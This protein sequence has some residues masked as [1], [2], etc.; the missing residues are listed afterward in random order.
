MA[1]HTRQEGIIG[2]FA[3]NPVAANLLML[4]IIV[5]GLASYFGI[6]KRTFPEFE[7]NMVQITVPYLGAAPA[8]VEEGVLIKIEEAVADV[9]GVK[10]IRSTANEGSGVVTVEILTGYDPAKALDDIKLRVDAIPNFPAETEKPVIAEVLFEQQVIWVT[11]YGQLDDRSR[12]TLARQVRDELQLLPGVR[13]V[14]LVGDRPYELTIELP[15][16]D[17][18]KYGLTFDEVA[19]AVRRSSIDLP[20]GSVKTEAGDILLRTKG[21]AYTGGEF[22]DVVLRTNPD[23]TRLRLSDVAT[24]RDE[25]ADA[26]IES[27]RVVEALDYQDDRVFKVTVVFDK[28]GGLD[29]HKTVAI[30]R[31]LREALKDKGDRLP[32][33]IV[34]FVSKAD[35]ASLKPEAA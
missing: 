3:R 10:E 15:E 2:W 5:S 30:V 8:E 24:I 1:T 13:K 25:F 4:I 23:G 34:Y 14:N 18:R 32:F 6:Q 31:H 29:P 7:S 35:A 26:A 20:G 19:T 21:Q 11:V 9:E 17:M 22:A 28:K 16:A 33:P 12:K 27:V